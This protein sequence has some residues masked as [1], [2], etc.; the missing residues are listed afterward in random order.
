M[1]ETRADRCLPAAV[2]LPDWLNVGHS[3]LLLLL[4]AIN[5]SQAPPTGFPMLLPR[6][7]PSGGGG[8]GLEF[9]KRF[10]LFIYNTFN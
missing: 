6:D 4:L 2:P 9:K 3:L 5:R 1:A 7:R 10:N 8:G